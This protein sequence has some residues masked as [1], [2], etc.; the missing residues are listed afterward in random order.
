MVRPHFG[1]IESGPLEGCVKMVWGDYWWAAILIIIGVYSVLV[2]GAVMLTMRGYNIIGMTLYP[3][4]F[5]FAV[6]FIGM[7]QVACLHVLNSLIPCPLV[8]SSPLVWLGR[9]L[10][11]KHNSA[12]LQYANCCIHD[13]CWDY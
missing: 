9:R 5:I 13:F 3:L 8:Y 1:A 7:H 2:P 10:Q 12:Y 11:G 6:S 4:L